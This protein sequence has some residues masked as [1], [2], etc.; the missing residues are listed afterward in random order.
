MRRALRPQDPLCS[1][2]SWVLIVV[3]KQ[4]AQRAQA[5]V[6]GLLPETWGEGLS[7]RRTPA[8]QSRDQ[9]WQGRAGCH[10]SPGGGGRA[11]HPEPEVFRAPSV[12]Q[13]LRPRGR[14]GLYQFPL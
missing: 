5:Q 12:F 1:G 13:G 11:V 2:L 6:S 14:G 7:Q 10:Q 4:S 9:A 3:T 8:L